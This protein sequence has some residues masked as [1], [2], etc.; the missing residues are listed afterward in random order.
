MST[1]ICSGSSC[2]RPSR[3]TF[4]PDLHLFEPD[5]VWLLPVEE[6]V[7]RYL[8]ISVRICRTIEPLIA[9]HDIIGAPVVIEGAW[10]LPSFV[11]QGVYAGRTVGG[12]RSLFLHE[13][14]SREIERRLAARPTPWLREQPPEIARNHTLTQLEYGLEIWRRADAMGLPVIASRPFD[15]LFERALA[16]LA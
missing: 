5:S 11:T 7:D 4:E 1:S 2:S 10:L 8:R 16:L 3:R 13:S 14:S 9:H 15:T 6:L 12:V